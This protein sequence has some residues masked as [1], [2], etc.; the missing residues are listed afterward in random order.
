MVV[1]TIIDYW[2]EKTGRRKT[3]ISESE[4]LFSNVHE[5]YKISKS[6]VVVRFFVAFSMYTNLPK[7]SDDRHPK[8]SFTAM[9]GIR[10]ITV[11]WMVL[12]H[13]YGFYIQISGKE[14]MFKMMIFL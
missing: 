1:G 9:H 10:A 2:I 13:V 14:P 12:L 8:G 5:R 3:S 11:T 6:D 4:S 7:I